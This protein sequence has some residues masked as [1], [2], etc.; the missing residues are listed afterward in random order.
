MQIKQNLY[1]ISKPILIFTIAIGFF[2]VIILLKQY[3][4]FLILGGVLSYVIYKYFFN[5]KKI[6]FFLLFF[7][8]AFPKIPLI[9]TGMVVP[10]RLEDLLIAYLWGIVVLYVIKGRI[11]IPKNM[12]FFWI[13]LYLLWGLVSTTLGYFRGDVTT[14]LF[15]L[16]KIEYISL[17]FFAYLV[18]DKENI[19]EF[20]RLIFITLSVVLVV[21]FIQYFKIFDK[22]GI[23]QYFLPYLQSANRRFWQA[24]LLSST[25]D[26]NYDLG[27]YFILI[28]PFLLSLALN[29]NYTNKLIAFLAF[30]ASMIILSFSGARTPTLIVFAMFF[31]IFIRKMLFSTKKETF[32]SV[33]IFTLLIVVFSLS[34]KVLLSHFMERGKN[35]LQ[36]FSR[37]GLSSLSQIDQSAYYRATKWIL[38]WENFLEHPLFGIGIGG[39]SEYF[40]G[41]DGQHIQT[42]GETGIVGFF[43][44]FSMLYYVIKKNL[45]TRYYLKK[46]PYNQLNELHKA[47]LIALSLAILGLMLNGITINIFD[48]SKVAMCLWAFIGVAA[49]LSSIMK[50]EQS[51]LLYVFKG[52]NV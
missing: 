24:D 8:I 42:L 45:K 2:S 13:G 38:V 23:T 6:F 17:F 46:L 44:F 12:I 19:S 10:I 41:A 27:G 50:T 47:F 51:K 4:L 5:I 49:K 39:F 28:V 15:F 40:V 34:Y 37:T 25:F 9:S 20:Y 7:V 30:S 31:F 22:L 35:L 32:K 29:R 21:A 16:R 48:S 52:I 11:K 3:I 18:I 43:L 36:V 1:G 26:G 33:L 14:P